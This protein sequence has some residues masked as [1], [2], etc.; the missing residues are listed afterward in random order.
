MLKKNKIYLATT[1]QEVCLA[2]WVQTLN[3]S[4]MRFNYLFLT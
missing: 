4:L 3:M 2:V 1:G